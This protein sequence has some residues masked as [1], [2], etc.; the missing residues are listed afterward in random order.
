MN[1]VRDFIRALQAERKA[2]SPYDTTAK[3]TRVEGNTVWVHI[4][5]GV[6]ETPVRRTVNAKVG[7]EVQVRVGGGKAWITGNASSPPTDDTAA[8]SAKVDSLVA[9]EQAEKA[10]K[11]AIDAEVA[12]ENALNASKAVAQYFWF[13][14]TDSGAGAGAG[15]HITTIPQ[16]D[17][18]ADP[19]NG[20]SNLLAQADGLKI[21]NGL[22]TRAEFGETVMLGDISTYGNSHTELTDDSFKIVAKGGSQC[23]SIT[24]DGTTTVQETQ[25]YKYSRPHQDLEDNSVVFQYDVD[26]AET[27]AGEGNEIQIIGQDHDETSQTIIYTITVGNYINT[28]FTYENATWRIVYRDNFLQIRL[29]SGNPSSGISGV[30]ARTYIKEFRWQKTVTVADL[31]IKGN[32]TI[33]GN[34]L[35]DYIVETGSSGIWK[36][37]K[38]ASGKIECWGSKTW[39]SV[40]C[41]TSAGGGYRSADVTQALPSGLFTA[42]DSCQATMKGSGGSGYAMALRTL[43]TTT[44]VTQMFW[45]TS[46]A[47]KTNLVV[48]YYI[49]GT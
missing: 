20:G 2:T 32:I 27:L 49:I 17:F 38:Y 31:A 25:S 3:V 43:C 47:T 36:W 19:A 26:M 23:F 10:N 16:E 18:L 46:S 13:N 5:G 11:K 40:A 48:D 37:N 39:S 22:T 29:T 44:T 7:D 28:T 9:Q 1:L 24:A 45:N 30:R 14:S 42:I 34:S 15:L 41:T 8:L 4:S 33:N 12:A 35:V 6:D 21:R